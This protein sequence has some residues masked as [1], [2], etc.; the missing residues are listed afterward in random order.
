MVVEHGKE[1]QQRTNPVPTYE[2]LVECFFIS[3]AD[4]VVPVIA[5]SAR[6]R[7]N[8]SPHLDLE[9]RSEC[10]IYEFLRE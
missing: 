8:R 3:Q 9:Q 4:S 6:T 10:L 5:R 2:R 7:G 1:A